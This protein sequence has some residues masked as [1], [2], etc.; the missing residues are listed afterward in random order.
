[1]GLIIAVLSWGMLPYSQ[2]VLLKKLTAIDLT[3]I[4]FALVGVLFVPWL[5][6]KRSVFVTCVRKDWK[7]IVLV[8]LAGPA[9]AM[10]L[11][12]VSLNRFSVSLV[13]IIVALEPLFTMFFAICFG[14]EKW[15]KSRF[16]A[17]L[18]S[19]LGLCWITTMHGF[20]LERIGSFF[21][22]ILVPVIWAI[23]TVVSKPLVISHG[24]PTVMGTSF[25]LSAIVYG[26]LF[27]ESIFLIVKSFTFFE[28]AMLGFSVVFSTF[29]AFFFWYAA[30]EVMTASEVSLWTYAIPL[31]SIASGVLLLGEVISYNFIIGS[32]M[33]VLGIFIGARHPRS[34]KY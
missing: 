33:I 17:I 9:S 34:K 21:I 18:I 12:N 32:T 26:F 1:M 2:K 30:L 15:K 27:D 19:L 8:S 4:R 29:L 5:I 10:L 31:I 13:A 23:N 16:I 25:L 14:Q 7:K 6:K 20:G 11:Y 24:T 22:L 28:Y 3:L